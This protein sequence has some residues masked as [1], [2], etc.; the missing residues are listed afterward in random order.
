MFSETL[1][2]SSR[3]NTG[4]INS[5]RLKRVK[6]GR[7]PMFSPSDK[8]FIDTSFP[9]FF[10]FLQFTVHWLLIYKNIPHALQPG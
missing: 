4:I 3:P 9:S 1:K 5:Q 2:Q 10:P 8:N 7:L 6:M